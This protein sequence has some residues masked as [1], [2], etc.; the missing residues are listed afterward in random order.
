MS[1]VQVVIILSFAM[2][3]VLVG[4][5]PGKLR[6]REAFLIS[7]RSLR[8]TS[9]GFTI[10]ASK[11]GGGLLVTYSTLV[12]AFGI[13]A[14]WVFVGYIVGYGL[15]YRFAL[16]LQAESRQHNYYTLADYFS[17]NYGA[18]AGFVAGLLSV[19]SLFGWVLTNLIAGSKLLSDL[20]G[21][22]LF[23]TT[24]SL[25]L[26]IVA[27][28]VVG[29]FNSVV[30]TDVLQY[31]ALVLIAGLIAFALT[32]PTEPLVTPA[33]SASTTAMPIGQVL[34]LLLLGMVFPMGSA[35]LWQRVY[36][37]ESRRDLVLG[38]SIASFSFLILGAALSYVCL[39]IRTLGVLAAGVEPELALAKGVAGLVSEPLAALWFIA[40][41]AAILS[42]ADTFIYTTASAV[43]QDVLQR[44][45][46]IARGQVV[47]SM[48]IAIL[49][50]GIIGVI[51]ALSFGKVETVTFMFVAL[52]LVL[53]VLGFA[54]W[55]RPS[56]SGRALA[57]SGVLG[58]L[59]AV[60]HA[61]LAESGITIITAAVGLVVT[62]LSITVWSVVERGPSSGAGT[63]SLG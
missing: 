18:A 15:F 50:L 51:G 38:L 9:S 16:R 55:A 45:G 25:T 7:G 40:F 3:L 17:H 58:S 26:L 1:A 28:L 42:S 62:T 41:S 63:A 29:G 49:A 20:S 34:A 30:R 59:A 56:I 10:A 13:Q 11:V 47:I 60:A 48:K 27:Y 14:F 57:A 39:R 61:A 19:A 44:A 23:F 32:N 24:T 5:L 2:V 37:T 6:G 36:A 22:P 53:G 43:V 52:T 46:L 35:E 31:V 12:F 4:V 21:W 33:P 8:G 54:A